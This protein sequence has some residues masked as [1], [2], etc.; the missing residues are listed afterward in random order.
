MEIVKESSRKFLDKVYTATSVLGISKALEMSPGNLTFYYPTKEHLLAFLV[1]MLCKFQWKM[2]QEEA[3]DGVSS[4]VMDGL[5]GYSP[6]YA[7]HSTTTVSGSSHVLVRSVGCT[8]NSTAHGLT[9]GL[10]GY[11]LTATSDYYCRTDATADFTLNPEITEIGISHFELY[12]AAHH[13]YQ[14]NGDGTHYYGCPTDCPAVIKG[15]SATCNGT[16]ATCTS[17]ACCEACQTEYGTVEQQG[18][19]SL[20]FY[21]HHFC[22]V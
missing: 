1:D 14:S 22:F 7:M 5:L 2:M 6:V 16:T 11:E 12:T 3:D 13:G 18:M 17:F 9:T 15:E 19:A 4:L 21:A 20:R 8:N 10:A